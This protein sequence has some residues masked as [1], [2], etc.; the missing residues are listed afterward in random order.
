MHASSTDLDMFIFILNVSLALYVSFGYFYIITVLFKIKRVI[1]LFMG[2]LSMLVGV[3]RQLARVIL[4]F[5]QVGPG[6]N[7]NFQIQWQ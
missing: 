2:E 4:S 3:R 5:C 1:Y 6:T 7:L